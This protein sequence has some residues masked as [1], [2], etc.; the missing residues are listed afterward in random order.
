M[1]F[2]GVTLVVAAIALGVAGCGGDDETTIS[3][4]DFI[5]QANE[6][7]KTANDQV[8]AASNEELSANPTPE[9]IEAFWNDTARPSAEEQ[10]QQIRD[11]GA[12][13]GDEEQIDALLAAVE[14]ATEE[15]QTAVDNGTFGQGPDP[16]EEANRL[17][18]DY[19][20]TDCA[21]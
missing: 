12:P 11:L 5:T 16:F 13:E 4:S 10:V 18:L 19:G 17:S 8:D 15:A 2:A 9:E 1:K 14:S 3:K 21:S 20:L 7:C 6:I